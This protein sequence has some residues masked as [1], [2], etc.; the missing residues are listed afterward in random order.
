MKKIALI[1]FFAL[2]IATSTVNVF[3]CGEPE[4]PFIDKVVYLG[5]E[6]LMRIDY[7]L[8]YDKWVTMI[9]VKVDGS[10]VTTIIPETVQKVTTGPV[11]PLGA[12]SYKEFSGALRVKQKGSYIIG[13]QFY[14]ENGAT[15]YKEIRRVADDMNF[16]L[17]NVQYD[18]VTDSVNLT[19]WGFPLFGYVPPTG[20]KTITV[21]LG[22][23]DYIATMNC[24][25]D[26]YVQFS[27][28]AMYYDSLIANNTIATWFNEPTWHRYHTEIAYPNLQ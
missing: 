13:F 3:A 11:V 8:Y 2:F 6:G 19:Y 15:W 9:E 14:N 16:E 1:C 23:Y 27:V 20:Q 22:N 10:A 25:P 21:Q 12:Y 5:T 7:H 26:C 28:D 17:A 4:E 24:N 18:S